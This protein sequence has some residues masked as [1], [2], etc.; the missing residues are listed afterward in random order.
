MTAHKSVL[1][2]LYSRFEID[3]YNWQDLAK[4]ADKYFIESLHNDLRVP[5]R[6]VLCLTIELQPQDHCSRRRNKLAPLAIRG[7]L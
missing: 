7:P 3:D 2:N 4:L 1:A 5:L 6:P